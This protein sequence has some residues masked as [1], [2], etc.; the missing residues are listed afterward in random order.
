METGDTIQD[1]GNEDT[2]VPP[3]AYLGIG[4]VSNSAVEIEIK[5]EAGM[6]IY[7]LQFFLDG[8]TIPAGA[9]ERTVKRII[10]VLLKQ[11][12]DLS[13]YKNNQI[14]VRQGDKPIHP[15][16]VLVKYRHLYLSLPKCFPE[17]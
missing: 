5:V 12:N 15:D 2:Y 14:A 13:I 10:G 1:A 7:G 11:A 16:M 8:L 4:N 3:M 6:D 17:H 9:D